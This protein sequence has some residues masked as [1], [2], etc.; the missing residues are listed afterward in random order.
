MR[1]N[2]LN[3]VVAFLLVLIQLTPTPVMGC[4]EGL[5]WGMDLSTVERHLGV[6]LSPTEEEAR[7]ELYEVQ[8]FKMSGIPVNTLRVRIEDENGLKQLAYEMDYE[9]MTE[10]LAGLRH[11]FGPPVGT[12]L[13]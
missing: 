13:M 4:V 10:V 8:N 7:R 11:R 2:C 9:N 6:S 5:S 3:F 12:M 1:K